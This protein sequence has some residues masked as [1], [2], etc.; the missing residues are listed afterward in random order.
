[1]GHPWPVCGEAAALG[2]FALDVLDDGAEDFGL[3]GEVVIQRAAGHPGRGH[4]VL[5]RGRRKALLS[6]QSAGGR[7]QCGGRR[8]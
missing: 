4:D 6:E 5:D 1:M 3:S 8:R 2:Y 7:G